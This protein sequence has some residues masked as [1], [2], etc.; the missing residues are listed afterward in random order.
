MEMWSHLAR[1]VL[2]G[3]SKAPQRNV[4][5]P[6]PC[7]VLTPQPQRRL[8]GCVLPRPGRFGGNKGNLLLALKPGTVLVGT[9]V[10]LNRTRCPPPLKEEE[11]EEEEESGA[12]GGR[13]QPDFEL[14]HR[15]L[16][17]SF[18]I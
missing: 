2:N 1:S 3:A 15:Y 9:C 6:L 14:S 4:P 13:R 16:A 17:H 7:T 10:V 8:L 5:Y 11:E 18:V 12:E